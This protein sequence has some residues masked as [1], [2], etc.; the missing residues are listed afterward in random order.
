MNKNISFRIGLDAIILVCVILGWWYAA[1]PIALLA[2]FKFP[3]YVELVA[4]GFIYDS[5]FGMGAG[6]VPDSGGI[7]IFAAF[8]G[9]IVSLVLLAVAATLKRL[10]R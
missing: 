3:Y 7:G 5:L 1:L 9:T 2:F 8:A 10:I 4:A 6:T